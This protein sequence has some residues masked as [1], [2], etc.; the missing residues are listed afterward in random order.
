LEPFTFSN[1]M[2]APV[3]TL[4]GVPVSAVHLDEKIYANAGRFD[5][6]RYYNLRKEHGDRPKYHWVNTNTEY[7]VFGG[8]EHQWYFYFPR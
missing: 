1:G 4:L 3:G 5:G 6:F 7:L 8:G 2:T